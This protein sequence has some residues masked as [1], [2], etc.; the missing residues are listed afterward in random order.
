MKPKFVLREP[1][2]VEATYIIAVV[3]VD[4][5]RLRRAT[6]LKISPRH[7]NAKTQTVRLTA[8]CP[9][10]G[11]MNARLSQLSNAIE[12]VAQ[13]FII[14]ERRPIPADFW[15]KVDMTLRGEETRRVKYFSD[16]FRD[17]I[18]NRRWNSPRTLKSY[19]TAYRKF[20]E[21]ESQGS[22]SF[23]FSDITLRFY[24]EFKDFILAQGYSPNYFGTLIKC[25]KVVYRDARD[26]DELHTLRETERRGFSSSSHTAR[27]IY[28]S[29]DELRRIADVE[30]TEESLLQ[31][32]PGIFSPKLAP[33]VYRANLVRKVASLRLIRDKF[34]LGAFTALRVSDFNHLQSVNIEGNFFRVKTQKTGVEVVIPIH[35]IVRRMMERGF[36]ISAPISD[37]KINKHIKEVAKMAGITYP[38]Y[39][40]KLID[41]R[42]VEG[43]YPKNELITTHT[44]RRSAATNMYKAGIPTLSI[45]RITGHTTERSFMKYIKITAEENAEMLARNPFFMG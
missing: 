37:Q 32:F 41:H 7:W 17:Y 6:G 26:I 43:I 23:R 11:A 10:A 4:S 30:I 31:T 16:Y 45:M 25:I 13:L 33:Q 1:K 27:T 3:N 42:V 12:E 29:L 36:D 40:S 5:R 34:I 15:R 28:L 2:S 19:E 44:A 18:K 20:V 21:F 24:Q 35:P 38:C 8:E 9:N 14:E 22:H 39:G